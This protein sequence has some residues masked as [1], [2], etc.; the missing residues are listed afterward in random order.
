M[1][2][3]SYKGMFGRK[4]TMPFCFMF[5]CNFWG[6]LFLN[7]IFLINYRSRGS[8]YTLKNRAIKYIL[9]QSYFLSKRKSL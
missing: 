2:T 7:F 9:M 5:I 8:I 4:P 3:N 1:G 6:K